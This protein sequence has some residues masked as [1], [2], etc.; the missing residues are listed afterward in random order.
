MFQRFL[1][2]IRTVAQ[3]VDRDVVIAKHGDDAVVRCGV[4]RA[5]YDPFTPTKSQ[6]SNQCTGQCGQVSGNG[7]DLSVKRPRT[8]KTIAENGHD[9]KKRVDARDL[10][11]S[12]GGARIG[13]HE[14]PRIREEVACGCG[15]SMHNPENEFG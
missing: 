12:T 13:S 8:R 14:A 4:V 11:C 7:N 1:V 3:G 10:C 2:C 15:R 6:F 9:R 5:A